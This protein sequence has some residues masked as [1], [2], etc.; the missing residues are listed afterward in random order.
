MT[1]MASPTFLESH[2]ANADEGRFAHSCLSSLTWWD[3]MEFVLKGV[4]PLYAFL[5]FAD[6]DKVLNLSEVLMRFSMV[7]NEYESLFQG[8]PADL[9]KYW[10]LS[11]LEPVTFRPV[12][13]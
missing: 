10:M 8:Y 13:I 1:S 5:R 6:Q 4:E 3:T 7:E 9:T 12:R 11:D 2:F